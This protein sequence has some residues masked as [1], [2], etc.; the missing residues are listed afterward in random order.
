M[1]KR[2]V[3][4]SVVLILMLLC[5]SVYATI[6]G[7][8]N[9]SPSNSGALHAGDEFTVTLSLEDFDTT[10]GITAVEGYINI[11]KDVLEDLTISSIVTNSDGKVEID[12]NNILDIYYVPELS[13]EAMAAIDEGITFNDA[14]VSGDGDYRIVINLASAVTPDTDILT[15]TFKVKP[16]VATGTYED[17]ITYSLF[18]VFSGVSDKSEKV[19]ESLNVVIGAPDEEDN[20]DSNNTNNVID[21]NVDNEVDNNLQD[22]NET[23]T[24]NDNDN[25]NELNNNAV[26]NN[27]NEIDDDEVNNAEDEN[28]ENRNDATNGDNNQNR[29]DD[30]TAQGNLPN[31][32]YRIIILPIIALI[33]AGFIFYKK[34]DKYSKF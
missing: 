32:G 21:N 2:Q 25:D 18:Q 29:V 16:G 26:D 27:S 24:D 12:E 20:D 8:I 7:S 1:K 9:I 34:Y 13:D 19:T 22:E 31:T 15:V 10:S 6:S 14:P 5:T 4:F 30:T 28:N 17:A 33:V 11:N 23:N 3:V